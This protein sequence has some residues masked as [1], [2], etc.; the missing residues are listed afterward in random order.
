MLAGDTLLKVIEVLKETGGYF[1]FRD[2]FGEEYVIAKK[3]DFGVAN[4]SNS[5]KQL[6]LPTTSSLAKAV[7][8]TADR[9]DKTPDFVLE[10]INRQIAKYNDEQR[11]Q[12]IDDL[13]LEAAALP[14]NKGKHIR[15]EPIHGDLPPE[16][17]E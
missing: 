9:M 3:K 13:S 12:E 7:Q 4:H 17:Q 14:K 5:E 1:V 11:E 16:L 6:S 10:S 15:F 2:E 8:E